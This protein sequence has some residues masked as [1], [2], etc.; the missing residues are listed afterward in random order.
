MLVFGGAA[1]A[2]QA[3][4]SKVEVKITDLGHRTYMLEGAGGNVTI[5]LGDDAAIM[6]DSELAPMH[7]KLKAAIATL[8]RAPVRYLVDTHFHGDHTGGNA[9]F[10]ED[11]AVVVAQANVKKRL[12]EGS[13]NGRTGAK[14]PGVTGEA[15]PA[16]T[17]RTAMSLRIK[18]RTAQLRHPL[19]AHTDGDTYV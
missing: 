8:T 4:F 11:G 13:V 12:A 17:Y 14:T 7:D 2:Q 10:A 19:N 18:G 3:D 9:A 5:A 15:L 16:K 6:V 1:R